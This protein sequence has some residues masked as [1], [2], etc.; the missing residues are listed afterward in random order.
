MRIEAVLDPRCKNSVCGELWTKMNLTTEQEEGVQKH[1]HDWG[2][3][4]RVSQGCFNP[5]S[6]KGVEKIEVD[7]PWVTGK[8][9]NDDETLFN[10]LRGC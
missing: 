4:V 3:G 7:I 6:N 5:M 10:P 1:H 9:M 8:A 2:D